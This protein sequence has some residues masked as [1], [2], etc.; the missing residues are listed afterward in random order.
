VSLVAGGMIVFLAY[1]G[2]ELIANAAEDVADPGRTLPQAYYIS[3]LFVIV[4]YLLMAVVSVGSVPVAQ[5]VQ[6]RDYA[7]AIAARPALGGVG[8]KMIAIAAML[9]T[10]SAINA[11][12]YGTERLSNTIARKGNCPNVW[13]SRSG[14]GR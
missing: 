1:E 2:F 4:L 11:T 7:L 10:A 5:L 9:S 13:I 3:V 12:L 6:A 14:T 8:F